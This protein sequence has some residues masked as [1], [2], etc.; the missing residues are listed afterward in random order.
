MALERLTSYQLPD[1]QRSLWMKEVVGQDEMQV[2][3]VNQLV[4][5]KQMIEGVASQVD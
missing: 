1:A 4:G 5:R 2:F 3:Q